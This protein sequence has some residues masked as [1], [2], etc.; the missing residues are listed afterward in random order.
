M[1]HNGD[2]GKIDLREYVAEIA[3]ELTERI[4]HQR[5]VLDNFLTEQQRQGHPIDYC[6]LIDCH[7]KQ[8]L[9]DGIGEAI[10][11]LEETRSSFKSKRLEDLRRK[12][13]A[14]LLEE[15]AQ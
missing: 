4:E 11:V 7:P 13:E 2:A 14:L 8:R 12:L 15:G 10:A 6:P 3:K 5:E 9:R 1:G